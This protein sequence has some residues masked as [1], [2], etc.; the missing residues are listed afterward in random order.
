MRSNLPV[1]EH[2]TLICDWVGWSTSPRAYH[3]HWS[4]QSPV[5]KWAGWSV[6]SL[7]DKLAGWST[8]PRVYHARW[9]VQSPD[10]QM[11]GLVDQ[12]PSVSCS[13][14]GTVPRL[15]NDRASRPVP[16]RIMLGGRYSPQT[17]KWSGWSTSP[18]AYHARWSVQSPNFQMNGLVDQFPSV[19]CSVVSTVPKLSNKPNKLITWLL[20][21]SCRLTN[22]RCDEAPCYLVSLSHKKGCLL[23]AQPL[24]TWIKKGKPTIILTRPLSPQKPLISPKYGKWKRWYCRYI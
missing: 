4:V 9:S 20:K 18:R 19:L 7:V 23:S 8:S 16:E 3:A 1:P 22:L 17:F 15:S 11:N 5:D 14:V 12:S 13:V 21:T 24:I 2:I 10:F 6:Q